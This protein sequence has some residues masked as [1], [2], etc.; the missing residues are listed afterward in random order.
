MRAVLTRASVFKV[1]TITR[2]MTS[3]VAAPLMVNIARGERR[4]E[5]AVFDKKKM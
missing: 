3:S 2:P 4:L 1:A 5:K